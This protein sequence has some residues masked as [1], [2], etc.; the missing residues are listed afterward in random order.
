MVGLEERLLQLETCAHLA[1]AKR[2]QL[3][4]EGRAVLAGEPCQSS[5]VAAGIGDRTEQAAQ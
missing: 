5:N 4:G 2:A 1:E 3:G